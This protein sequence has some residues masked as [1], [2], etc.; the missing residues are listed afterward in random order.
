MKLKNTWKGPSRTNSRWGDN[1]S[2]YP[3]GSIVSVDSGTVVEGSSPEIR[4]RD[5]FGI[6]MYQTGI[7]KGQKDLNDIDLLEDQDEKRLPLS[8][9]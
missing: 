6:K 1:D 3:R 9:S 2:N 7:T 4:K 8:K 5:S